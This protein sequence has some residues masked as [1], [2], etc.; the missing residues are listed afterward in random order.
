MPSQPK[1][2]RS[3]VDTNISHTTTPL[4]DPS[5]ASITNQEKQE[6][7]AAPPQA[8]D[9]QEEED[10]LEAWNAR[11]AEMRKLGSK[12]FV[13]PAHKSGMPTETSALRRMTIEQIEE[14]LKNDPAWQGDKSD[15]KSDVEKPDEEQSGQRGIWFPARLE[16]FEKVVPKAEADEDREEV[17]AEK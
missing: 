8:K 17:E 12:N 11:R 6:S 4:G 14:D 5:T 13:R 1:Q 7:T 16:I 3:G 9:V 10:T 2:A 15:D